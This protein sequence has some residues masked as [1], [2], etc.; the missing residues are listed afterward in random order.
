MPARITPQ[1]AAPGIDWGEHGRW[2]WRGHPCHWRRLG[3]P[4]APPLVLVH[5]FGAGS[6]HWRHN[7]A[8]LVRAGWCVYAL[9]LLGFG[10]S[11]QRPQRFDNRLWARQLQAFLADVVGRPAVVVGHSLG[12]L[13]ALSCGVFFPGWVTAV[14]AAPLPDP[15]LL[16]GSP[17]LRRRP[18]WRRRLKRWL[19]VLLCRLLPLEL[20]VPLLVHSPLLA[21][22]IQ[23]AYRRPVLGDRELQRLIAWPARRPGAVPALRAM[24]IAMALRPQQATAPALLPRLQPPLLLIWGRQDRLVPLEM[25]HQCQRLRSDLTLTVLDDAGHCPHDEAAAAWNATLT[26]W[27][28]GIGLAPQLPRT[29]G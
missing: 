23:S 21:L 19:V 24:S 16:T 20:V 6:G 9:D 8:A 18:P 17:S 2:I 1:P 3:D 29:F 25:A 12:G 13:V 26:S 27:L 28:T 22:G 7:A 4:A 15:A 14:V 5:G 10:A 11:G